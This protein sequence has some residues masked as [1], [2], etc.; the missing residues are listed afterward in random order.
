MLKKQKFKK[1]KEFV[2]FTYFY[3]VSVS[4]LQDITDVIDTDY[5]QRKRWTVI[6]T[7]VYIKNCHLIEK[8]GSTEIVAIKVLTQ[9]SVCVCLKPV[10]NPP[11]T[12]NN[13]ISTSFD[14]EET[15]ASQM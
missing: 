10:D 6:L 12:N 5:R 7:F 4:L 2:P 11:K 1:S 15:M 13:K 9:S 3:T 14:D 8:K